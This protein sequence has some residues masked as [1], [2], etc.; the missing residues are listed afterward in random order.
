VVHG[1]TLAI[2]TGRW[3][4]ETPFTQVCTTQA[5][6]G[7]E[8]VQQRPCVQSISNNNHFTAATQVGLWQLS[9]TVKD[10]VGAKFYCLHALTTSTIRLWKD[11]RVLSVVLPTIPYHMQSTGF[12]LSCFQKLPGLFQNPQNVFPGYCCSTATLTCKDKRQ[13]LTQNIQCGSTIHGHTA[14]HSLQVQGMVEVGTGVAPSRMVC[15]SASVNLP[16]H[17]KV[18]FC[19]WLTRMVP[20]KGP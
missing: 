2:I 14:E 18:L 5:L 17:H 9:A 20:E 16:L 4:G 3:L 10:F 7:L 15:E 1:L 13:L 19:H 6:T 12:P 8:T 11:D